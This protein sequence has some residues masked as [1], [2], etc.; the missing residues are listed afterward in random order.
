LTLAKA[1]ARVG[2]GALV[3]S[4]AQAEN[5]IVYPRLARGQLDAAGPPPHPG[6]ERQKVV[7]ITDTLTIR[8]VFKKKKPKK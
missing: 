4:A 8:V 3:I 1:V 5:E 7:W 6:A 2:K